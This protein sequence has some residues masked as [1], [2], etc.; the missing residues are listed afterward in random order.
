MKD[1]EGRPCLGD[2]LEKIPVRL[3]PVGR[4]DWDSEGLIL[5]TND[6]EFA[7]Q[8]SHPKHKITKTYL[9]KLNAKIPNNKLEKLLN[10]VS[11]K[12]GGRVKALRIARVRQKDSANKDWVRIEISEGK[13]RQV[14]KMFLKVGYDVE[15]LQRISIGGFELGKLQRGKMKLLTE[16]QV[17][18]V[19]KYQEAKAK[20]KRN[21][22]NKRS[23]AK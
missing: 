20:P 6:G 22:S 14:R 19:F 4:L 21:I 13:N 17:Q 7:N 15:K 1:P 9:V 10:G 23:K 18:R 5:L 11:I 12:D 3:Y 8:I 16:K 2:Y